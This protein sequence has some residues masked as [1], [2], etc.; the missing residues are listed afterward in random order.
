[1][2]T[3][4]TPSITRSVRWHPKTLRLAQRQAAAERRTLN[5]WIQTLVHWYDK[6]DAVKQEIE[7]RKDGEA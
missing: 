5:N 7:R 3:N 1:M 6:R 2:S 4:A